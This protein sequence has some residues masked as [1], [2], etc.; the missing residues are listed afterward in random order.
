M[1]T[2]REKRIV[3][4]IVK[5]GPIK[6]EELSKVLEVSNRTVRN[7]ISILK[8][9]LKK[10]D[11]KMKNERNIGYSLSK[12]EGKKLIDLLEQSQQSNDVPSTKQERELVYISN[13][14]N[15]SVL[16]DIELANR[17][18]ISY[19]TLR[20]I[21]HS[22]EKTILEH[23]SIDLST[24]TELNLNQKIQIL[25]HYA[26]NEYS[27]GRS[28]SS[29][30]TRFLLGI[31][32]NLDQCEEIRNVIV[33][34]KIT[35]TVKYTTNVVAVILYFVSKQKNIMEHVVAADSWA[36]IQ[37][38]FESVC[39]KP[40]LSLLRKIY[41]AL[42][43]VDADQDACELIKE[44]IVFY[45]ENYTPAKNYYCD[46]DDLKFEQFIK[47]LVALV[48]RVQ[49]N[50]MIE[51][52]FTDSIKNQFA[53]SFY[54]AQQMLS[55]LTSDASLSIIDSEIALI[56]L[57]IENNHMKRNY[58]SRVLIINDYGNAIKQEINNELYQRFDNQIKIISIESKH[59]YQLRHD[60]DN[61]DMIISNVNI[62][63]DRCPVIKVSPIIS[64]DEYEL[65]RCELKKHHVELKNVFQMFEQD[66]IRV[67]ENKESFEQV[68]YNAAKVL[69][70]KNYV[71][72]G[73]DFATDV[74][75]RELINSTYFGNGIIIPH[76]VSD[77]ALQNKV[78]LAR[79][80]NGMFIENNAVHTMFILCISD[81]IDESISVLYD[82][83][84]ELIRNNELNEELSMLCKV[85]DINS[86]IAKEISKL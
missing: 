22:T 34:D 24:C 21:K 77:H 45:F 8:S 14:L 25:L 44:D 9:Y 74:I 32:V 5:N 12:S 61:I 80:R 60:F 69:E 36:A 29:V 81:E 42:G 78:F 82:L 75:N 52:E 65:I 85:E 86:M 79:I 67:Y 68:I 18:F 15:D 20:N 56:A 38:S 13:V 2:E 84:I 33:E 41:I 7:S 11:I 63:D 64:A 76:P 54:V 49:L 28:L 71:R 17:L 31:D 58:T 30:S 72:D 59:E 47:H 66:L 83:I 48:Y 26:F 39:T 27:S 19:N 62:S 51:I 1:I 4:H 55:Y 23:L 10:N 3:Y 40:E 6:T 37:N 57:Y 43:M 16:T 46:Y 35:N 53:F 73:I 70:Q 50:V